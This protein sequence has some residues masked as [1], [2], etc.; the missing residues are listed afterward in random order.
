M[1]KYWC[2]T[3]IIMSSK[4]LYKLIDI[5]D[6]KKYLALKNFFSVILSRPLFIKLKIFLNQ[7]KLWFSKKENCSHPFLR[8]LEV[9]LLWQSAFFL[10]LKSEVWLKWFKVVLMI[11]ENFWATTST[12]NYV[13]R[14]LI[15]LFFNFLCNQRFFL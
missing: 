3:F 15:D 4:V 8:F 14:Y 1:K 5:N 13:K 6:I 12:K 11:S 10:F 2:I 9:Q 7:R